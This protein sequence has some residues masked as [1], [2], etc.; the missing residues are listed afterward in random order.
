MAS[1]AYGWDAEE[2]PGRQAPRVI[3][4][5]G[6]R[7]GPPCPGPAIVAARDAGQRVTQ[8]RHV[9][10][11]PVRRREVQ[12]SELLVER[13]VFAQAERQRRP[14]RHALGA[15]KRELLLDALDDTLEVIASLVSGGRRQISPGKAGVPD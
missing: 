4:V 1:L 2:P 14:Q 7:D 6:V 9:A 8:A 10:V 11:R 12:L 13:L 15:E 5:V 3:H